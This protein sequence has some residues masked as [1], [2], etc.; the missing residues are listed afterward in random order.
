[1]THS[2]FLPATNPPYPDVKSSDAWLAK[3]ALGDTRS[4][5]AAF[6]ALLD[7]I[8]EAPPPHGA[9]LQILERLRPPLLAALAE[10]TRKFSGKPL[11]S[12]RSMTCGWPCCTPTDGCCARSLPERLT[13]PPQACSRRAR[14]IAP[15][16]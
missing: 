2:D 6:H 8:E 16:R 7:E 3:A 9:Y 13:V 15:P 12:S 1:M 11:R 5:C 10:H 4:A 14:C